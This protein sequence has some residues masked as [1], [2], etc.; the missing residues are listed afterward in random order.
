M[1]MCI[2]DNGNGLVVRWED[3]VIAEQRAKAKAKYDALPA[4][5]RAAREERNAI[6]K[7]YSEAERALEHDTDDN[8]VSRGYGARAEADAR[9]LAW[10]KKC[11]SEA[12]REDAQRLLAKAD[13]E[14]HMA[15]GA[16]TYDADG[17]IGPAEQQRRHDEFMANAGR[18]R[19][20]VQKLLE[21]A[22]ISECKI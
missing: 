12:M 17:W 9:L 6:S 11:P 4:N 3:D 10:R 8:N 14:E 16:L 19:A 7:L 1:G 18:L 20:E 15:V 13:H 22:K 2:G 21:Q 5:I